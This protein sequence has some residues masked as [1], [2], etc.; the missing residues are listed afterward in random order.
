MNYRA[1]FVAIVFMIFY[2]NPSIG[3][4]IY[5]PSTKLWNEGQVKLKNGQSFSGKIYYHEENQVV[6]ISN[7]GFVKA[8]SAQ[9]LTSFSYY[10]SFLSI[11]RSYLSIVPDNGHSGKKNYIFEI[12]IDGPLTL[13]RQQKASMGY[14]GYFDEGISHFVGYTTHFKYYF[15]Y[16][17]KV[18]PI[19]NFKKQ[20]LE[21]AADYFKRIDLYIKQRKLRFNN[22][23][24]QLLLIQYYNNIKS[25]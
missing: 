3:E 18:Y 6:Y 24:H 20:Y 4:E 2:V 5:K 7:K 1:A 9:N 16:E 13:L 19:R 15:L 10:D 12:V 22:I 21:L 11:P 8:L 23:P 14:D 17:G 25:A